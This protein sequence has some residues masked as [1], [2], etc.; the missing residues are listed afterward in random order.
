M[1]QQAAAALLWLWLVVGWLTPT[2]L[3]MLPGLARRA[4]AEQRP[5]SSPRNSTAAAAPSA[6]YAPGWL[7]AAA[8]ERLLLGLIEPPPPSQQDVAGIQLRLKQAG[9]LWLRWAAL[10]LGSWL[11][12]SAVVPLWSAPAAALATDA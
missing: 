2:L 9:V 12:C 3:L 8:V 10:L 7:P 4:V 6:E 1:Y 5:R 11:L